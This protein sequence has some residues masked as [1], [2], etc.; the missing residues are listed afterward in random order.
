MMRKDIQA[1]AEELA[2]TY[3]PRRRHTVQVR[4]SD[5]IC[6]LA[7]QV[8]CTP[9]WTSMFLRDTKLALLCLFGPMTPMQFR[10]FGPH[11]WKHAAQ[12]IKN[13]SWSLYAGVRKRSHHEKDKSP[14]PSIIHQLCICVCLLPLL[15]YIV[16]LSLLLM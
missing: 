8:G 15:F 3:V 11:S 7:E 16:I 4:Y 12:Y 10:L 14:K 2:Q 13:T 5:Y 9:Q 1:K 6:E